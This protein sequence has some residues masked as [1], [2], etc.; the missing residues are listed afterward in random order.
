MMISPAYSGT[1]GID[2][3]G[4]T[5]DYDTN[6]DTVVR[7]SAGEVRKRLAP[8]DLDS[9]KTHRVDASLSRVACEVLHALEHVVASPYDR[10][11]DLQPPSPQRPRC[12]TGH[13]IRA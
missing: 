10:G 9:A 1:V 7:Y 8:Y 3:F 5:P 13:S 6:I 4:R 12:N 2:V 11:W